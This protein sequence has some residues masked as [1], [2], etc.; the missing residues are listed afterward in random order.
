MD[1][2]YKALGAVTAVAAMLT[3]GSDLR[4]DDRTAADVIV[5]A[6]PQVTVIEVRVPDRSALVEELPAIRVPSLAPDGLAS[7]RMVIVP[8]RPV[9]EVT[10]EAPDLSPLQEELPALRVPDLR[11]G[12]RTDPRS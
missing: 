5:P 11:P 6:A 10:P 4:A 12:P 9:V 3:L 8:R 7:G 2:T 1:R